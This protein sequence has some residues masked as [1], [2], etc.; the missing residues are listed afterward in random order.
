M[1]VSLIVFTIKFAETKRKIENDETSVRSD[2]DDGDGK[3]DG[4]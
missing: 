4:K 3:C 1:R 2:A